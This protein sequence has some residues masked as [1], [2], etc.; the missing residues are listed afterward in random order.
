MDMHV[1]YDRSGKIL[2]AVEIKN[3]A[4]GEDSVP[5]PRPVA[6]RGQRTA[7]VTVPGEFHQLSFFEA[8]TQLVVTIKAERATLIPRK[9][10]RP[11]AAYQPARKP[12]QRKAKHPAKRSRTTRT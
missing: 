7:D 9:K 1:L 8:C 2:A 4:D 5:P 12:P 6:Q 11:S 10:K 3:G